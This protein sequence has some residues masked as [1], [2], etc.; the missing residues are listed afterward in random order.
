MRIF[1]L[2]KENIYYHGDIN[3]NKDMSEAKSVELEKFE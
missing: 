1:E 2:K 3:L